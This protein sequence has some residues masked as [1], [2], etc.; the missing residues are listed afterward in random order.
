MF[1]GVNSFKTVN[2]FLK[3]VELSNEDLIFIRK[4]VKEFNELGLNNFVN[5]IERWNF[6]DI[7]ISCKVY[8]M[9]DPKFFQY[10]DNLSDYNKIIIKNYDFINEFKTIMEKYII[11]H[12][13]KYFQKNKNVSNYIRTTNNIKNTIGGI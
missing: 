13:K 11:P 12:Y 4:Y 5:N 1:S 7:D 8:S 3:E 10:Y 2:D 6:H 9:I